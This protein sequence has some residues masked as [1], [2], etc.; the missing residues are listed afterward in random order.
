MSQ[1]LYLA[2]PY[3]HRQ[4]TV[5]ER[6]FQRI[7]ACAAEFMRAGV[8]VFSPISH[9][10]PIAMAGELPTGWEF[11]KDYDRM[12][13][14]AC[15][16]LCVLELPGYETSSGVAAEVIIARKLRIPTYSVRNDSDDWRELARSLREA[17][18]AD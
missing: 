18:T 14:K 1:L 3:S 9:T 8:H 5:R 11:W 16:A 4:L 13:I 15:S 2:A 17:A 7:N 10:H 12:M 6:R